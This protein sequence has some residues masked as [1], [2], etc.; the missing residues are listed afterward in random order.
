MQLA[1][2]TKTELAKFLVT[3]IGANIVNYLAYVS[4]FQIGLGL[5]Y[6]SLV[7]Y[8][9]G[10]LVSYQLGRRWVFKVEKKTGLATIAI[11]FLIYGVGGL[12]MS[13]IT[14]FLV[15]VRKFDY[16][17]SWLVGASFAT[18]NNFLGAKLL[19]FK[20]EK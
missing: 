4:S 17:V 1:L 16:H 6:A 13:F 9:L 12:G 2:E 15:G 18:I 10:L 20:R 8:S 3:G 11:F 5:F 19:V 14:E 7:G